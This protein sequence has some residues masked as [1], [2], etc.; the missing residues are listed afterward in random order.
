MSGGVERLR[1][2]DGRFDHSIRTIPLSMLRQVVRN[3]DVPTVK[4]LEKMVRLALHSRRITESAY[5][6]ALRRQRKNINAILDW[7]Q[8]VRA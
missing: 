4:R 3:A 2:S 7:R 6:N 8:S 5:Y 1:D